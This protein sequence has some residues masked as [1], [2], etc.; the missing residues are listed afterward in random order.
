MAAVSLKVLQDGDAYSGLLQVALR[1][2]G[3]S[4]EGGFS[5]FK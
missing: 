2:H 3:W 5:V 1:L 4:P